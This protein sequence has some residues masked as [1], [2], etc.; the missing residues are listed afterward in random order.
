MVEAGIRSRHSWQRRDAILVLQCA[1]IAR[2]SGIF[3]RYGYAVQLSL[4]V[5]HSFR[6]VPR[7]AGFDLTRSSESLSTYRD[8]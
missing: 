6:F 7:V 4:A 3:D 5:S 2:D 1:S 8:L